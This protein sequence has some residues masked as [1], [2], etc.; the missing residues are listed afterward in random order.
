MAESFSI[1]SGDPGDPEALE[2][3]RAY[4]AD[5]KFAWQL[6]CEFA[7]VQSS[8]SP[9]KPH[10]SL[11]GATPP[12]ANWIQ[13]ID[14]ASGSPFYVNAS[15]GQPV[16]DRPRV[17][18]SASRQESTPPPASWMQ[19]ANSATGVPYWINT[20]TGNCILQPPTLPACADLCTSFSEA[21]DAL[22]LI[23]E[24]NTHLAVP[25]CERDPAWPRHEALLRF[26]MN[27]MCLTRRYVFARKWKTRA[28]VLRGSRLY[29][30]NGKSGYPDSLEGSLAYMCSNPEPDGHYC[31]DL[32]G[33]R[34]FFLWTSVA[35]YLSG[36]FIQAA[37]SSLAAR[38]SMGRH[39]LSSYTP[40]ICI[41]LHT[42]F[43][44][45]RCVRFAFV[46]TLW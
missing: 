3:A 43:Q 2:R 36:A 5:V 8:I 10:V 32:K 22:Q 1:L 46:R 30:S 13:Q 23:V 14:V 41:I 16:W 19:Y 18:S 20:T 29:F 11:D 27:L 25:N 42:I 6:C 33:E 34:D 44:A 17:A 15:T 12:A 38:L 24:R 31:V 26:D 39:L 7:T 21:R 35:I 37:A 28:F 40:N 9:S 45:S 4:Y